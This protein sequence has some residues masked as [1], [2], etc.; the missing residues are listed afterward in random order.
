MLTI[1]SNREGDRLTCCATSARPPLLGVGRLFCPIW[2]PLA[3]SECL[4]CP[5]LREDSKH[6]R[7][8]WIAS[9]RPA[10]L[11]SLR[12][13]YWLPLYPDLMLYLDHLGMPVCLMYRRPWI[14]EDERQISLG[15]H[16]GPNRACACAWCGLDARI[17]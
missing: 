2:R 14:C 13:M 4:I 16:S 11:L 6:T 5:L 8:G 15:S 1:S 12:S 9:S 3:S 10:A 17:P 7:P